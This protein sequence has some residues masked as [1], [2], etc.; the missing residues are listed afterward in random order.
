MKKCELDNE[1]IG[2]AC[3]IGLV[4]ILVLIRACVPL[5]I[6]HSTERPLTPPESLYQPR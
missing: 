3:V 4:L 1:A 5:N 6:N 2:I